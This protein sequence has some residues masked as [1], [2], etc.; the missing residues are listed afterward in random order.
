MKFRLSR[1]PSEAILTVFH[2]IDCSDGSIVGS[3]SVRNEEADDLERHWLSQPLAAVA[4]RAMQPTAAAAPRRPSSA[5]SAAMAAVRRPGA[6]PPDHARQK[7]DPMIAPMVAASKRNRLSQQA[8][9][10]CC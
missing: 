9:L 1:K 5:L 6:L 2:V 4:P 8:V 10:R 7:E 3:I